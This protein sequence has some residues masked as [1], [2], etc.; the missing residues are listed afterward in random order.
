MRAAT[1]RQQEYLRGRLWKEATV[2]SNSNHRSIDSKNLS[3]SQSFSSSLLFWNTKTTLQALSLSFATNISRIHSNKVQHLPITTE[4]RA[5]EEMGWTMHVLVSVSSKT[6]LGSHRQLANSTGLT[7]AMVWGDY[8]RMERGRWLPM[9]KRGIFGFTSEGYR[10]VFL[11]C[12]WESSKHCAG[13]GC[14]KA[15]YTAAEQSKHAQY[16]RGMVLLCGSFFCDGK[17]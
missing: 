4:M 13:Q 2:P 6:E 7:T 17:Y 8:S 10:M 3:M 1:V 11:L 9:I 15:G 14:R 16:K 5:A 12:M